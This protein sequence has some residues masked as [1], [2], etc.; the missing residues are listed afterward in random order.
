VELG[1]PNNRA[2][3]VNSHKYSKIG[4]KMT[5][6]SHLTLA[7]LA[8]AALLAACG[9]RHQASDPG[10]RRAIESAVSNYVSASNH[11]DS[12]ALTALYADDA[13]LLPPDHEPIEGREAIGEFWSQGTD[14][15]LEVTT[16]RLEVDG[17]LGY[18]V[19]QYQ[20]PATDG[21]PADSGKYVMCLKRQSDGSWKLTADIWNSSAEADAP[22]DEDRGPA[23]SIT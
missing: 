6:H 7:G 21:E 15:G 1:A 4:A 5:A 18:L 17:D 8:T 13:V 3:A 12:E 23:H 10:S 11:G 20:L 9:C 16:L 19:G 22:T 2:P 14:S